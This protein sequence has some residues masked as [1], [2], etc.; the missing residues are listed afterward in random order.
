MR[1][2]A[3]GSIVTAGLMWLALGGM[4]AQSQTKKSSEASACQSCGK[5][6]ACEGC[7]KGAACQGACGQAKS[8]PYHDGGHGWPRGGHPHEYKCVHQSERP[9]GK[10]AD[11]MSAQF[12][13]LGAEGWHLAKAD[14]GFWCFK[15]PKPAAN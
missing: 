2:A 10:A 8:C 14:N 7:A 1:F 11:A 5:G 4:P 9:S 3:L 15:R 13:A 12:S 6:T